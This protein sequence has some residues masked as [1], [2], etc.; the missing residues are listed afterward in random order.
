MK[1]T[2]LLLAPAVTLGQNPIQ[3]LVA[4]GDATAIGNVTLI[5]NLTIGSGGE[6]FV[7]F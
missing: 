6:W 3:K 7:G 5:N 1:L 4:A 2:P